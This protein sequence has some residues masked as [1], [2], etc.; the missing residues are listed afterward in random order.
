MQIHLAKKLKPN[1]TNVIYPHKPIQF[2]LGPSGRR[3][4]WQTLPYEAL[5]TI[6]KQAA[7][8]LY[9]HAS[10]PTGS[11]EWLCSMSRLCRSFHEASVAA[12]LS[13]PP[14]YPSWRAES[15]IRLLRL[16]QD[17]LLTNYR[18]KIKRLNIEV[19]NLLVS[20]NE[21]DLLDLVGFAP[22]LEHLRLYHN[23]DDLSNFVWAQP[24]ASTSR[25]W[26]YPKELFEKFDEMKI[27]LKS[28]EWNGRF[29]SVTDVL[30]QMVQIHKT[31]TFST[32]TDLTLLN[33]S[34]P[35]KHPDAEI[36]HARQL[37]IDAITSLPN[38]T[39][40][41]V[42]T[43]NIIDGTV[44]SA[45][46]PNLT[47]LEVTNILPLLSS[48]LTPYLTNNSSHL[49]SLT[50][51]H[52]QSMSLDF[53]SNLKHTTPRLRH[54]TLDLSYRDPSSYQDVNPLFD[55][56]LPDGPPT[57]PSSLVSIDVENLRQISGTEADEFLTSLVDSAGNLPWLRHLV[58][59]AIIRDSN[60]RERGALR[61]KW[62]KLLE[63]VFLDKR[64]PEVRRS[65]VSEK[66]RLS[67]EAKFRV[68][69]EDKIIADGKGEERKTRRSGR[70]KAGAYAEADT[71]EEDTKQGGEKVQ[72]RHGR[73]GVV[74]LVLSNQ[75]PAQEQFTVGDFLDDEPSDDEDYRVTGRGNR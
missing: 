24:S 9:G 20:K 74:T 2:P 1:T 62:D 13:S 65:V 51:K 12:L 75:R 26:A 49:Q 4:A 36:A 35:E 60:H 41:T 27:K 70:K 22:N 23:H 68:E 67:K 45:L 31:T 11:I 43:C 44:L 8:P 21:I 66:E 38:L 47:S 39:S 48:H 14:L 10:R 25:R 72:P 63:E 55:D 52:N 30:E 16:D 53:L 54:L 33:L 64:E 59:K 18:N 57:W 69:S 61:V 7:Y 37:L 42:R 50:L 73:C 6:M 28:F 56:A 5:V 46:P 17:A 32:L 34:F 71:D 58:V 15:L 19:K 40:L 3:P 29:P